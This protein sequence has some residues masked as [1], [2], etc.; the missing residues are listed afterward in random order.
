MTYHHYEI[1]DLLTPYFRKMAA[2]RGKAFVEPVITKWTTERMDD[3]QYDLII[4]RYSKILKKA[5][6]IKHVK[7]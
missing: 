4:D 7:M 1:R 3:N 2:E 5:P 6:K